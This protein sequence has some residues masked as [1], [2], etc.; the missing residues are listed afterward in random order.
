M[1]GQRH[2][3]DRAG[4]EGL[5][6]RADGDAQGPSSMRRLATVMGRTRP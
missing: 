6:G 1:Q 4:D 3:D 2:G 5:Q